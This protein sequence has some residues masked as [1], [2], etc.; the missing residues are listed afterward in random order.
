[1]DQVWSE[2]LQH[3]CTKHVWQIQ[4]ERYM[5]VKGEGESEC[6]VYLKAEYIGRQYGLFGIRL[7]LNL[8]FYLSGDDFYVV[9]RLG[10]KP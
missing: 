3:F 10:E 2:A 6:V 8:G 1:M 4:G 7:L 5:V 9:S